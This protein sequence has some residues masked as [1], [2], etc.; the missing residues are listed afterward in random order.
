MGG[1]FPELAGAAVWC[2]RGVDSPSLINERLVLAGGQLQTY[3]TT[4]TVGRFRAI[5][6]AL[7]MATLH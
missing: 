5:L 7:I 1:R 6:Y 3:D 2:R 4:P